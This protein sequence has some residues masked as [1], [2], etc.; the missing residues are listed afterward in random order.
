[1]AEK[2]GVKTARRRYYAQVIRF[3]RPFRWKGLSEIEHP[4]IHPAMLNNYFTT[5]YRNLL[6]QKGFSFLNI[7]GLAIGMAACLILMRYVSFENSYESFMEH[8]DNLYRMHSNYYVNDKFQTSSAYT[9]YAIG[10]LMEKEIPEI[11]SVFRIH[12]SY[13]E[14]RL[15]YK[16]EDG[17][18]IQHF[19]KNLFSVD[20]TFLEMFSTDL[21]EGD[22]QTALANPTSILL[23]KSMV[24]KYF[25]ENVDPM[26][27]TLTMMDSYGGDDYIVTGIFADVPPNSHLQYDFLVPIKKLLSNGQYTR[28]DGWGWHNFMTYFQTIPD[29]DTTELKEKMESVFNAYRGE[30]LAERN[31]SWEAGLLSVSDIHL[32][33]P[34]K[35][36]FFPTGNARSV[37]FFGLIGLIILIIAW[38]NYMNLSTARAIYRAREVGIRKTVGASR[39]ELIKQFLF[40]SVIVNLLSVIGAL[41]IT[42]FMMPVVVDMLGKDITASQDG[43]TEFWLMLGGMFLVGAILSGV[44]PAL[45]LSSFRPVMVLKGTVDKI[46]SGISLRKVLVVIQF[47]ASVVLIAG[48]FAVY[49]QITFLSNQDLGLKLEQVVTFRGPQGMDREKDYLPT[50]K[51][52]KARLKESPL[53]EAACGADEMPGGDF[54]WGTRVWRDGDS[55]D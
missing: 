5:A 53:V 36:E 44:Y 45:V 23:S 10:P 8:S 41:V 37:W 20:S 4:L 12:P 11:V 18:L 21:I 3:F 38:V 47:A 52:F 54:N 22:A 39:S 19:E 35:D 32:H 46:S 55:Q 25:G 34:F 6:R 24:K 1:M 14:Q 27:K 28:D 29:V 7:L 49:N 31:R 40:E 9:G 50:L 33:S 26:G 30:Y 16:S 13:S 17:H 43:N 48:T 42:F 51:T 15:E 2:H